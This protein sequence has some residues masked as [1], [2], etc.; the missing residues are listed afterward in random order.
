MNGKRPA[1]LRMSDGSLSD[2]ACFDLCSFWA[3]EDEWEGS[4]Q[5][6]YWKKKADELKWSLKLNLKAWTSSPVIENR[7]AAEAPHWEE[8]I[9][10][11]DDR[12]NYFSIHPSAKI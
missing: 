2:Q 8:H 10:Q 6:D 3:E 5:A 4:E 9:F 1:I 7:L 12:M 11:W